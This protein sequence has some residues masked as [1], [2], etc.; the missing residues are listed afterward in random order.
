MGDAKIL[1]SRW[2][3]IAAH[4]HVIDV[5]DVE[6]LVHSIISTYVTHIRVRIDN[7]QSGVGVSLSVFHFDINYLSQESY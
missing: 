5:G 4:V 3:E 6:Y 7:L 1:E 2:R